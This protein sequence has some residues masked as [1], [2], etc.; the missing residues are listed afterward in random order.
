M[1]HSGSVTLHRRPRADVLATVALILMWGTTFTFAKVALDS[2]SPMLLGAVRTLLAGVIVAIVA[3]RI[4]GSPQLRRYWRQYA[5]LCAFNVVGFFGLQMLVIDAVPSGLASVL[6][7]L[8]PVL[9]AVLAGPLLGERVSAVQ[10]AGVAT[11]FAGIVLVSLGA[12]QGHVSALGIGYGIAAAV[13][14]SLGTIA[15]KRTPSGMS[16]WWAL[17]VPFLAG[18][19]VLGALAA[20]LGGYDVDWS[21]SFVLAAAWVTFFGTALS[22]LLWF[23]LVGDG[24]AARVASRIFFVPVLGVVFGALFLGER[25]GLPVMLGGALVVAGVYLANRRR[26][27][28]PAVTP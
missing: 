14:W 4:D 3:H 1:G 15:L 7:Y 9:T 24:E 22:W 17:A 27:V 18:S 20:P 19:V 23:W 5:V 28:Q 12:M 11:A 6:I 8:Q 25:V 10:L 26:K 13:T 21:W 2:I 16:Q